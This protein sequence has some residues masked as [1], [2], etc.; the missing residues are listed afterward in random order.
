MSTSVHTA[1]APVAAKPGRATNIALWVLQVLAAA[2]FFMAGG[3]KFAAIPD[4]VA[5]FESLGMGRWFLYLTGTLEIAGAIL[6]LVPGLAAWGAALLAVVMVGA[7]FFHLT[8]LGGSVVMP[9]VLLIV[10]LVILWGRRR[11]LA[12]FM[13]RTGR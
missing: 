11:Q 9:L 12:G 1:A 3:A 5:A 2:M 13:A 10:L 8:V 4:V 7:I 6:L